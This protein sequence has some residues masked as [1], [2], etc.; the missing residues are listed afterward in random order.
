MTCGLALFAEITTRMGNEGGL[1]FSK[2]PRKCLLEKHT[3]TSRAAAGRAG[4]YFLA[5]SPQF[6]KECRTLRDVKY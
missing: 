4:L 1:D 5:L 6:R 2:G 3:R